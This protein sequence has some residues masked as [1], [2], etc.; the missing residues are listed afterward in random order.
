M[1]CI[2]LKNLLMSR[3]IILFLFSASISFSSC[4]EKLPEIKQ[5]GC[6][7][8]Y[9]YVN[10]AWGFSHSGFTITPSG[11]VYTFDKNTIW[12]FAQKDRLSISDLQKNIAASVK[13][14]TLIIK[15]D[16]DRYQ[17]L[18]LSA[19]SGTLSKAVSQGADM[20]G[21]SCKIIVPDS[22]DPQ[23]SYREVLLTVSGDFEQHN[24]APEAAVIADWLSKMHRH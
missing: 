5:E 6:Y 15:S 16:I 4:N 1:R 17:Q 18:A 23:N 13:V 8:Q 22:S 11:E 9:E 21:I 12:V 19:M 7:F 10:Y 3:I 24:L 2:N 20:G 14:D